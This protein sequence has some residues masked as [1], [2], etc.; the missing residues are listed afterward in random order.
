M[1]MDNLLMYLPFLVVLLFGFFMWLRSQ[2]AKKP[3]E[4]HPTR[5]RRAVWAMATITEMRTEPS[6]FGTMTRVYMSVHVRLPGS[7]PYDAK[8][9]W[10]VKADSLDL[11]ENGKDIGVKVDPQNP[12]YIYPNGNWATFVE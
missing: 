10:L 1:T 5:Q 3:K 2:Q 8:T 4:D 12:Q 6:S 11:L 9:T 7:E